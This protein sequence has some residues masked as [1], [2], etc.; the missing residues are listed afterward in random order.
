MGE[1][2]VFKGFKNEMQDLLIGE[3][4]KIVL[5]DA[6]Y[7]ALIGDIEW[8]SNHKFKPDQDWELEEIG[9]RFIRKS[10]KSIIWRGPKNS[11]I[12]V[13]GESDE[14]GYYSLLLK[15]GKS[16]IFSATDNR[17]SPKVRIVNLDVPSAVRG[18][19]AKEFL[20]MAMG[21]IALELISR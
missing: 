2:D 18:Q 11:S 4:K 16:Y 17:L 9:C 5:S 10:K 12:H 8:D 6:A 14:K 20:K 7:P 3:I 1:I 13:L 21:P 15:S 19:L